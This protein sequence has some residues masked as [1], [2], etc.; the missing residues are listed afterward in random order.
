MVCPMRARRCSTSFIA[1][2]GL[3]LAAPSAGAEPARGPRPLPARAQLIVAPSRANDALSP[4]ERE[5]LLAG[6]TVSRPLVIEQKRGRYI[7]GVSYQLLR[8]PPAEV[9]AALGN[10]EALPSLLPR[11]KS[12]ELVG[13]DGRGARIELTQGTRLVDGTYTIWLRR[14]GPGELAFNL[15]ASRPHGI[16]DVHGFARVRPFGKEH[17]LLTLAVALDVGPGIVRSL[18]ED[19]IQRVILD[20]PRQIRDQLEASALAA[21][22]RD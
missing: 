15:D 18:F 16:A 20:A 13:V 12:A 2:L 6:E 9:L 1:A 5:A 10:P 14:A 4:A 19:R 11:T 22:P 7:G 17:T 8:V 3:A 21:A